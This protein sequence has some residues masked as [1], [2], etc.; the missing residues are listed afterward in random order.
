MALATEGCYIDQR[1]AAGGR[2]APDRVGP[3][4]HAGDGRH[5]QGQ[6]ARKHEAAQAGA[7]P[8]TTTQVGMDACHDL[9]PV[10][11]PTR[12]AE[13]RLCGLLCLQRPRGGKGYGADWRFTL[14]TDHVLLLHGIISGR[15]TVQ[16][17]DSLLAHK[18]QAQQ[19]CAAIGLGRKPPAPS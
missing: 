8:P 10:V 3:R 17:P 1:L 4:R 18:V 9:I 19:L 13:H 2:G 7:S 12:F 5:D 14:T 6:H 16:G 11:A 15:Y